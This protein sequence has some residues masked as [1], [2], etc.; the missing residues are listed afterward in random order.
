MLRYQDWKQEQT[1][2]VYV[3]DPT[4]AQVSGL[5]AGANTSIVYVRML[6]YKE[7][8]QELT[9]L[10]YVKDPT[11]A[12]VSGLGTGADTSRISQTLRYHFRTQCF[13]LVESFAEG[14]GKNSRGMIL[15]LFVLLFSQNV[16]KMLL[17]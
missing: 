1:L 16:L 3:K 17:L 12:Q 11:D 15:T 6:R 4:D 10:V 8:G 2:L 9:L 7:W 14:A 5:G 13:Q